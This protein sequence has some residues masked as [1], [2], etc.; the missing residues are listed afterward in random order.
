[1]T[2]SSQSVLNKGGDMNRILL[3]LAMLS[4]AVLLSSCTKKTVIDIP[5]NPVAALT[6]DFDLSAVNWK[7]KKTELKTLIRRDVDGVLVYRVSITHPSGLQ[8]SA[9]LFSPARKGLFPGVLYMHWLGGGSG[10]NG[11]AKEFLAEAAEFAQGGAVCIVPAG[12]FP[13]DRSPEGDSS[14]FEALK[15]Q[16]N[17]MKA[18]LFVLVNCD[19]TDPGRLAVVGHDYGAMHALALGASVKGIGCAVIM[20][21]AEEYAQWN[22]IIRQIPAEKYEEYKTLMKPLS[23]LNTLGFI[24]D[25]NILFQFATTDQYVSTAAAQSIYD[26]A[27]QPKTLRFYKGSG[28]ALDDEARKERVA[29]LIEYLKIY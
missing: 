26:A 5:D 2:I 23:P 7:M 13:W 15:I 4:V 22:R 6:G 16:I 18:A 27:S 10:A 29:F 3:S 20:A 14:D 8:N 1:M 28:H 19:K 11:N 24:S 17:M 9:Y 25:M 12:Y 21:P